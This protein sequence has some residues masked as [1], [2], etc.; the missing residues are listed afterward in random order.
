MVLGFSQPQRESVDDLGDRKRTAGVFALRSL[1]EAGDDNSHTW[2]CLIPEPLAAALSARVTLHPSCYVTPLS[3]PLHA[4]L[5]ESAVFQIRI[6]DHLI[7][8]PY[9]EDEA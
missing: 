4:G 2:L 8:H 5:G 6:L 1:G 3:S 7:G 9:Q